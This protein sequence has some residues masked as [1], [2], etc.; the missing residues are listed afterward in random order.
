MAGSKVTKFKQNEPSYNL[1][2]CAVCLVWT[3][4]PVTDHCHTH[5]WERGEV[6]A[7][8]NYH[9]MQHDAGEDLTDPRWTLTR[10]PLSAFIGHAHG[11]PECDPNGP[12]LAA[13]PLQTCLWPDGCDRQS[14][15]GKIYCGVSDRPGKIGFP[16][17]NAL[18][19]V[20][21]R[22]SIARKAQPNESAG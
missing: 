15:Q 8:C 5:G 20:R 21:R 3:T 7:S 14:E 16:P 22:K 10:A 12:D 2:K 1:A 17:H 4:R 11:C 19:A 13:L 9:M 18:A 6:C